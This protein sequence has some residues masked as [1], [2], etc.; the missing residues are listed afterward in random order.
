MQIDTGKE[1]FLYA[2][3]LGPLSACHESIVDDTG[4]LFSFQTILGTSAPT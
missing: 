1:A 4:H 2:P 3:D